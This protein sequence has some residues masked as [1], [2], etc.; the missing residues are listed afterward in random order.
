MRVVLIRWL[1]VC[2]LLCFLAGIGRLGT[3]LGQAS[4][5]VDPSIRASGTGKAA[6]AAFWGPD[7]DYWRNPALLAYQRGVRFDH[8]RTKL[9]PELADDVF[10]E[11]DR[12]TLAGMGVGLSLEGRPLDFLGG[13]RLDYGQTEA[14]D[15]QG[16]SYGFFDSWED[17]SSWGLALSA[18]NVLDA[19]LD[20]TRSGDPV[21]RRFGDI[22]LGVRWNTADVRL[23]PEWAMAV[24]GLEGDA[25]SKAHTRDWGYLLRLSP[26]NSVDY[27]GWLPALDELIEPVLGGIAVEAAYGEGTLNDRDDTIQLHR[28]LD[29]DPISRYDRRGF[30]LRVAVGLPGI[31]SEQFEG[32]GFGWLASSLSPLISMGWAW[33]RAVCSWKLP[34]SGTRLSR[35]EAEYSGWEL[36]LA[37]MVTLRRGRIDDR[38]GEIHGDTHGLG[39][40]LKLGDY[41]GFRY[42]W[43]TVPQPTGLGDIDRVGYTVFVDPLAI[44]RDLHR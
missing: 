26:Y 20:L 39:L 40:G 6:S 30:A 3:A 43:A 12:V 41:A 10:F 1:P 23:A 33:D 38:H 27:E 18:V 15:E 29:R 2:T 42:D 7:P 11:S 16:N 13:R 5:D 4:L 17:V 22:S 9:I 31:F 44:W 19:V 37:N 21:L 32:S 34:V 24:V 25:E 28:D 14:V 8:G 35:A 36:E